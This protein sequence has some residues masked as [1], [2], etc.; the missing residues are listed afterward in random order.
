MLEYLYYTFVFLFLIEETLYL[1]LTNERNERQ[2]K[3]K[4]LNAK[5]IAEGRS[6]WALFSED[7]KT[8]LRNV[9][10]SGAVSIIAVFGGLFTFQWPL[11]V[12]FLVINLVIVSPITKK[13]RS[14]G[15]KTL[16]NIVVWINSLFGFGLA[17]FIL[18]N[19]IHLHINVVEFVEKFL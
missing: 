3:L 18:L 11:W 2:I 5:H 8:L 16:T 1:I 4:E 14:I 13:S 19:K 9:L 10:Y 15:N 17:L 7:Y 12:A 6:T